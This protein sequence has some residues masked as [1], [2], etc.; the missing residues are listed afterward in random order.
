MPLTGEITP[1]KVDYGQIVTRFIGPGRPGLAR[2]PMARAQGDADG[3]PTEHWRRNAG[4]AA[5]LRLIVT[6]RRCPPMR[7]RTSVGVERWRPEEVGLDPS[8]L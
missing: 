7:C 5:A 1:G 6:N 3:S 8:G 4:D 2:Q